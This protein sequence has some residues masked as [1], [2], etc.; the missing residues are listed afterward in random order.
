[1]RN[2]LNLPPVTWKVKPTAG[3]LSVQVNNRLG[4][5]KKRA[6]FNP[7]ENVPVS[8]LDSIESGAKR[9]RKQKARARTK[10]RR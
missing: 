8:T 9:A 2:V 4:K 10:P 5:R 1:M 6:G 3:N 7:R